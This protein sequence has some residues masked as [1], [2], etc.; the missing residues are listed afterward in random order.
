MPGTQGVA[1]TPILEIRQPLQSS[2]HPGLLPRQ[3][4]AKAC[5]T[6]WGSCLAWAVGAVHVLVTNACCCRAVTLLASQ[7]S[8]V[9]YEDMLF[10][11]NERWNITGVLPL[12][13]P[14]PHDPH[15]SAGLPFLLVCPVRWSFPPHILLL[16]SCVA[17]SRGARQPGPWPWARWGH[18]LQ[19]VMPAGQ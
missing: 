1:V 15:T 18:S 7:A 14:P 9:D 4:W 11:D 19:H 13:P 2:V 8:G 6:D 10:F 16:W 17:V 12:P 3:P 5:L